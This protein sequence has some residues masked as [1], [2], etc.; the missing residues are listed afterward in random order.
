MWEWYRLILKNDLQAFVLVQTKLMTYAET[1]AEQ[2]LLLQ[3]L[4]LIVR[5]AMLLHYQRDDEVAFS[6][7]KTELSQQ[8]L[9]LSATKLVAAME[10]VLK[11]WPEMALNVAFQN[12]LEELTLNLCN[13]YH[14]R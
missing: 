11:S 8:I 10:L 3:L 5:D 9:P 1:R 6:M 2:E 14:Q 7:Y 12:I 13:C 4:V